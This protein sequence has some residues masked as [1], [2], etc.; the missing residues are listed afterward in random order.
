MKQRYKDLLVITPIILV[1]LALFIWGFHSQKTP[2]VKEAMTAPLNVQLPEYET[3]AK[4]FQEVG[5]ALGDGAIISRPIK[6]LGGFKHYGVMLKNKV[7]H[8]NQYGLHTDELD[9][10]SEGATVKVV[11]PGL[12]GEALERFKHNI[13]HIMAKY[14]SSSYD[15]MK[16]NCEH[17]VN[18]LAYGQ[19]VSMQ[20][21]LTKEMVISYDTLIRNELSKNKLAILIPV[22]DAAVKKIVNDSSNEK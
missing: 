15:A 19:K 18:E 12:M 10:F 2:S 7:V 22:Y 21:N 1:I 20:A 14:K 17:F 13:K 3:V 16:N 11:R 9:V 4:P 5:K 6:G 8:F